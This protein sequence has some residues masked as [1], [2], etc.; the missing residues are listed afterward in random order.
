MFNLR[1]L[2]KR[3]AAE[4]SNED[5]QYRA[6]SSQHDRAAPASY[7][8]DGGGEAASSLPPQEASS[9][10]NELPSIATSS[11]GSRATGT[12][13]FLS[14]LIADNPIFSGGLGLMVFGGA[15]AMARRGV[16][17]AAST[18]QRRLLISLEIPSKD[19]AYPWFLHWMAAQARAQSMRERGLLG[20]Q[21]KE[22]L[23]DFLGLR[24]RSADRPSISSSKNKVDNPLAIA[25]SGSSVSPVRILSHELS[26]ETNYTPHASAST[27]HAEAAERGQASFSLVPGPGTHWFRYRGVWMRLTRERDGKMVDLSTGA[28]WETVTLT[29]LFAYAHLF[30]QLLDEARQL[31]LSSTEG[32]TVIY[33]SWG[34]EWRPFGQPRRTRELG[35]VVLG[36]GKKEAIVSDVKR[37]MERD[38]WYAERGIPYR[39]GYL[40]HGAPGSGKSSF[41]TALAGHLDFNICL[42]NLSERGLTDDKLNHL[43][44]NAPDRSILLLEDVDAAFLGRQQAAEDGYQASVTFSGLLNALDGVASGESRIIFMTTNHIEKLDPALIRP[45]RVDLIAEL[46]DAERDQVEELMAR[47][48]RTTMREHKIKQAD[49]PPSVVEASKPLLAAAAGSVDAASISN[50]YQSFDAVP[51][52]REAVEQADDEVRQLAAEFGR[53]VEAEAVA[54]RAALGLGPDGRRPSDVG[55]SE[56]TDIRPAPAA[57][58]GVSMAELQGLFIRFPDD[59][60]A[61]VE[62][63]INESASKRH[64]DNA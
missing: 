53:I 10:S 21:N 17:V 44:S 26:V 41:I 39:R 59:P 49:L 61:A 3:D 36:K 22:G 16:K 31:A 47:F 12:G 40:L 27:P 64:A 11:S 45:G 38:R 46:G 8:G 18:A 56:R 37:F 14:N 1:T 43:L 35:S 51:G 54:R 52:L 4:L 2:Q 42:L 13:S 62:A 28:P 33:T 15:V 24:D 55:S 9:S 29:T 5:D 50:S 48:Y 58:G 25:S 34:P 19:R 23:V 63:F 60:R 7:A 20:K 30:P 6:S 57:S 32:K